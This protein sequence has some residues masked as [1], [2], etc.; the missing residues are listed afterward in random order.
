M[1]LVAAVVF[2][3]FVATAQLVI[4]KDVI[5]FANT[6]LNTISVYILVKASRAY[7]KEVA[8]SI[9]KS[10]KASDVVL[11]ELGSWDGKDRRECDGKE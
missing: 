9:E 1:P 4:N 11:A 5:T 10:E 2:I 7:R 3:G 6:V 8:P